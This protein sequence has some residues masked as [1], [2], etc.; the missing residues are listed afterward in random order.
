MTASAAAQAAPRVEDSMAQRMQACTACHGKEGRAARDGYYPR[1]AGKPA[2]YLYHQ[3]ANFR[4]GRRH[5]ALMGELLAP[6]SDAYLQEI[7]AYFASLDLPYPPPQAPTG[8]A[9]ERARGQ[10]L[11]LQG[12]P[13]RGIPACASCHGAALTGVAPAVPGLLG[14]PRDYLNGQLGAWRTGQR[15][16]HAP[17]CMAQ[18]AQRL[19]PEDIGSLSHWLAAQPLPANPHPAVEAPSAWPLPCGGVPGA[20]P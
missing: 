8:S 13:S 1:I 2:G 4:D 14:L 5:Y 16:A 11:V 9:E 15:K 20:T 12:D 3:L 7:A 10:R 18:I 6:L 19:A 17:D